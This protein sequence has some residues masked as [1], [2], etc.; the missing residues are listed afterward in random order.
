MKNKLDEIIKE[1]LENRLEW[2]NYLRWL[3]THRNLSMNAK[4]EFYKDKPFLNLILKLYFLPYN[5]IKYFNYICDRH[6]FEMIE[7]EIRMLKKVK[8]DKNDE[9]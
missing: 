3:L 5:S 8:R 9:I 1:R 2:R 6:K 7:T 4:K